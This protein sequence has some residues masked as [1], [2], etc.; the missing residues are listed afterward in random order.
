MLEELKYAPLMSHVPTL[1]NVRDNL[2][3]GRKILV[4]QSSFSGIL[5]MDADVGRISQYDID[6]REK[7]ECLIEDVKRRNAILMAKRGNGRTSN[8]GSAAT[9]SVISASY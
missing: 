2:T 5:D 7:A 4:S 1:I 3:V 6:S 9:S 8:D